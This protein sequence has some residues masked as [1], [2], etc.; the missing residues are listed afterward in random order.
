M[1]TVKAKIIKLLVLGIFISCTD[2]DGVVSSAEFVDLLQPRFELTSESPAVGTEVFFS[3]ISF[4]EVAERS[5]D[6]GNGD[7]SALPNPFTIYDVEGVYTVKLSITDANGVT[8]ETSQEIV[9]TPL[10]IEGA[11]VLE[12]EDYQIIADLGNANQR[13]D[14]LENLYFNIEDNSQ[15]FWTSS[16]IINALSTVVLTKPSFD[17][18]ILPVMYRVFDGELARTTFKNLVFDEEQYQE[19][20]FYSTPNDDYIFMAGQ[21]EPAGLDKEERISNMLRFLNF[22]R[23]TVPIR[24]WTDQEIVIMLGILMEERFTDISNGAVFEIEFQYYN[25]S[26]QLPDT[27][28]IQKVGE[29]F[30]QYDL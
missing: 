7:T 29:I 16:E 21:I 5:W 2:E 20:T 22:Y 17:T 24:F 30:E 4:G 3:D 1:K 13:D 27:I 26:D 12:D 19:Y 18:L 25:G 11:Y 9:I 15:A 23:G 6:F 28:A 8:E 14:M 10:I